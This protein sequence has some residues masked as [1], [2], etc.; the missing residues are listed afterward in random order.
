MSIKNILVTGGSGFLGTNILNKLSK[1]FEFKLFSTTHTSV[2]FKRISNVHY[3]QANLENLED[4][5]K[6]C[7]DMDLVL[8][9]AAN[10]SGAAVMEKTPL[11]HLGPNIRMNINMTEA[12]YEAGVKKFI[13]ISS[14]TVYPHVDFSVK[15]EDASFDFFE[16]YFVV[17]WMK[18][19]SEI[20]MEIYSKKI[21]SNRMVTI[22]VRPGNLY[23]PYDKFE[24]EKSKVIPSLIKKVVERHNPLSV[25]GDGNDLKDFLY[26]DDFV[27]A[28]IE[29]ISKVDQYIILNIASGKGVTIKEILNK[30]IR[31]EKAENLKINFDTS[32]PTMIPKRLINIEKAKR[33]INFNPK[34]G[35]EEGLSRT[36][37]WY[38]SSDNK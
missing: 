4:C 19:F 35:L 21:K 9:C 34:I 5:R 17:G 38:I 2:N 24:E 32:M 7:K 18:R 20:I 1:I 23:G 37:S 27:D 25:W 12:A 3:I 6:V 36:I 26:V 30:I 28:I 8:M 15:E 22:V 16:K 31:I 11:V 10:S 13:F 33:L 29:I 14:N